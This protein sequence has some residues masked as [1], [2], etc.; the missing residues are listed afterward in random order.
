MEKGLKWLV[1]GLIAATILMFTLVVG[2]VDAQDSYW[3]PQHG[4][5]MYNM[6]E[7]CPIYPPSVLTPQVNKNTTSSSQNFINNSVTRDNEYRPNVT[8]NTPKPQR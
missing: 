7:V 4:Q 5:H 1:G 2:S 3:H 6:Y 8:V